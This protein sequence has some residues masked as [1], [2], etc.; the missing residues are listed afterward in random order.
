M[1]IYGKIN[2]E[3]F[4]HFDLPHFLHETPRQSPG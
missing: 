3:I 1:E 4:Y 2:V